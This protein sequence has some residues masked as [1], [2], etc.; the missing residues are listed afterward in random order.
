VVSIGAVTPQILRLPDNSQPLT[1]LFW[2][3]SS[4]T[5]PLER[6]DP[7]C[8][9]NTVGQACEAGKRLFCNAAQE[10]VRRDGLASSRQWIAAAS[11]ND[12]VRT[13]ALQLTA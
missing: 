6:L 13:I 1:R 8:P 5:V 12:K 11:V 9:V 7:N 2:V 3:V 10:I 4:K